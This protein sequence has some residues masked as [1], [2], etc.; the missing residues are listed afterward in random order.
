MPVELLRGMRDLGLAARAERVVDLVRARAGT[1]NASASGDRAEE[2][3]VVEREPG[4]PRHAVAGEPV[5]AR[6]H[7]GGDDQREEEQREDEPQLPERE[8]EDDDRR[9]RRGSRRRRGGRCPSWRRT[10]P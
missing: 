2:R 3:E 10:F 4:G 7:R 6:P 5:D 8:R 1:A 9:R